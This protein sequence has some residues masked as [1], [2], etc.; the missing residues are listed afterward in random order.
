MN[1]H[2]LYCY[3][4]P[5]VTDKWGLCTLLTSNSPALQQHGWEMAYINGQH[6]QAYSSPPTRLSNPFMSTIK[7]DRPSHLQIHNCQVYLSPTFNH[8]AHMS[9]ELKLS[10]NSCSA[11][12]LFSKLT[13]SNKTW[14]PSSF[15]CCGHTFRPQKQSAFQEYQLCKICKSQKLPHVV[16]SKYLQLYLTTQQAITATY[17]Y[18]LSSSS[19]I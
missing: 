9:P 5:T 16:P 8:S 10:V 12:R 4:K 17:K 18:F 3:N 19:S 6:H 1:L 14:R 2:K 11:I 13:P 15:R 7:A